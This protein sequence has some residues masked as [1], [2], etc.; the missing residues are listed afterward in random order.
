MSTIYESHTAD[1]TARVQH[2]MRKDGQWF[3]RIQVRSVYGYRWTAW[4]KTGAPSPDRL[5][6]T[7][8]S[9]RLPATVQS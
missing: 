9:A 6:I 1:F 2:S 7:D 4:R 3:E 8:R 5:R